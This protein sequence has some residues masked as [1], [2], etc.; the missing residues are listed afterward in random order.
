MKKYFILILIFIPLV[1]CSGI[2]IV[3]DKP[4]SDWIEVDGQDPRIIKA[5]IIAP[6]RND[7]SIMIMM[8]EVT[9]SSNLVV[10]EI[11]DSYKSGLM[12]NDLFKEGD[13]EKKLDV[14]IGNNVWGILTFR[15]QYDQFYICHNSYLTVKGNAII[16]ITFFTLTQED[17]DKYFT[18]VKLFLE[19]IQLK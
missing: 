15:R 3:A 4:G 18:E 17:F 6:D 19:K 16:S 11:I 9:S 12:S 7:I 1:F 8:E 13:Y 5:Y 14:K 10:S 2:E